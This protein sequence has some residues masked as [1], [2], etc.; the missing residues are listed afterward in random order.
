MKP[1]IIIGTGLAGYTLARELRKLNQ[2]TPLH[3]LTADDGRFYSKPML[4]NA[5]HSNKTPD[6]L[7]INTAEHMAGQLNATIDTHVTVNAID[8]TAHRLTFNLVSHRL[9]KGRWL[10]QI[11]L[12]RPKSLS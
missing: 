2:D 6:A 12:R 4:S 3:L 7:A 8:S 9:V 11:L 10:N 1:I 5:F